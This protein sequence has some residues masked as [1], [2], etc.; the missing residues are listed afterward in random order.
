MAVRIYALAKELK[1]DSKEL[2]E[3][4]TKAG[5]TGKGSALASLT[6]DEEVKLRNYLAGKTKPTAKTAAASGAVP[7]LPTPVRSTP[8]PSAPVP[9]SHAPGALAPGAA[10][11]TP[12]GSGIS[13]SAGTAVAGSAAIGSA[14]PL[15]PSRP[16]PPPIQV[17]PNV[18]RRDD[19]IPPG[20][21]M[22]GRPTQLDAR[23]AA[24]RSGEPKKRSSDAAKTPTKSGP[25][26]RLGKLPPSQSPPP[27]TKPAEPA[28]QKPDIRLPIDVIRASTSKTGGATPLS[29]HI[30]RHDQKQK[31]DAAKAIK[32][33]PG[34]KTPAA[35]LDQSPAAIAAREKARKAKPGTPGEEEEF[36]AKL[37]GREAR[38]LNR[39]R[40][41]NKKRDDEEETPGGPSKPLRRAPMQIKRVGHGSTA[42][43]RKTKVVLDLPCTVRSFSEAIGIP[44]R[45]VLGKLLGMGRMST[46]GADLDAETAEFLA[47]EL[48]AE[49]EFRKPVDIEDE[50]VSSATAETDA[51]ESLES[52][53]PVITVLGHVDH[54][55]TTLLDKIIGI[56]VASGESGGI[57]Q[58]IRAYQIERNDRKISFVDTPGH[59]A[60]TEMRARGAN[61]TDLAVLVVAADDGVMPQTEEAISHARAAGVPIVVALNKIDLPGV[62]IDRIY[63]Q[64][65]TN[66][67]LPSEWGGDTEV[68]KTSAIQSLGLDE[69]LDR[70]LTL[71][72]LHDYQ[73]NPH[74]PAYGTCLEAQQHEGRGIVTKLIVQNGT[75]RVG[76]AIVCGEA[77]GRVKAMYD[78]LRSN[79]QYQEAGP[80]MPI[81]VTGLDVAPQAGEHFY[82]L[83]DIMQARQI[84]E[85]RATRTRA[86]SLSGG[87][88]HVTL[89]NLFDRLGQAETKTLNVILRSDVRGSIE[90]IQKELTKLE[91]PEVKIRILQATVGGVSEAD[92]HLADASD[93]VIIAFNVV[94][95][96]KA[97]NLAEQ[98]GVQIR[99]YEIIY[100]VTEDLKQ[101]LEGMLKPEEQVKELGRAL[102]LRTFTISRV[103]TIAG[104]RV[105]S[106]TMHRNARI[107]VIRDNRI[108]GD[109]ALDSLKR[110]KDDAREVR[111][112]L[113]C[114]IKL[115][116]FNDVKEADI[117]ECFRI[118][119]VART[120]E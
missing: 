2:V 28:P 3:I 39:K 86:T 58:H 34:S 64:L 68:V 19:Y 103:G 53:P 119:E 71:A 47:L 54:G 107:R 16:A 75:L 114:G 42:A 102:V 37:G 97:R 108:V 10:A 22:P 65:A 35:P 101:A 4:C 106:G 38:Q 104:C 26:I 31:D 69:L 67:L 77:A 36:K 60:F 87:Q 83:P 84:A 59:E 82:V 115:A 27:S 33:K 32:G 6:D 49:I 25:P 15:A 95:D 116:G 57:T 41:A 21:V 76:D 90:A 44:A 61:V 9:A 62:N 13:A 80:S 93:A 91:H 18:I 89:E 50:L 12:A 81:D 120:F 96:E 40:Q 79:V 30:R 66:D 45:I 92:V 46:I 112:G 24:E 48:G 113:E 55:K 74:R 72:E 110:E 5:I 63:Q 94:P 1:I 111:E 8:V 52:R 29:E 117:L 88:I 23:R 7:T 70:L 11:A 109:Y 17:E 14:A 73:A 43:P 20:G 118:E 105:L 78:T 99:R 51:P 85:Q 56:N 98:K 100:K